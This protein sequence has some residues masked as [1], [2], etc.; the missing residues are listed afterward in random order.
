MDDFWQPIPE[1]RVEDHTKT[2]RCAAASSLEHPAIVWRRSAEK[3]PIFVRLTGD[4]PHGVTFICPLPLDVGEPIGFAREQG[5][6]PSTLHVARCDMLE[7][8]IYRV[9]AH[10]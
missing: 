4:T 1:E 8:D 7:E 6:R 9:G 2:L 3:D 5:A 10:S